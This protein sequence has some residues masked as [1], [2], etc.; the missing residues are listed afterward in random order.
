MTALRK[1]Q[2][3]RQTLGPFL[4]SKNPEQEVMPK[5]EEG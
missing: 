2:L 3:D 4:H 1:C 5:E